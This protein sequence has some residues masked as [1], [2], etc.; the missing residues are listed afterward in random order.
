MLNKVLK[1]SGASRHKL[2]STWID[3]EHHTRAQFDRSDG[4]SC[5]DE[6]LYPKRKGACYSTK[7]PSTKCPTV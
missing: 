3:V 5:E 6:L 2:G 1:D 4:D 7:E